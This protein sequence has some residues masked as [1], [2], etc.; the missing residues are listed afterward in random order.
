[1]LQYS[2]EEAKLI[3]SALE[4]SSQQIAYFKDLGEQTQSN[5]LAEEERIG[6]EISKVK[7]NLKA[8]GIRDIMQRTS[9]KRS[10]WRTRHLRKLSNKCSLQPQSY[11]LKPNRQG[12]MY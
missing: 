8:I 4:A 6:Q 2:L 5:K 12:P 9:A 11:K 3:E 1:V 10:S 7:S